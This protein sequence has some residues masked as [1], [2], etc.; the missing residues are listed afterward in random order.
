MG[1]KLKQVQLEEEFEDEFEDIP[2]D[3]FEDVEEE[4]E[5]ADDGMKEERPKMSAEEKK[6]ARAV[7]K[8]TAI[9]RK[10]ARP[11]GTLI[12]QA[13][14]LWM[15][16]AKKATPSDTRAKLMDEMMSLITGQIE[17]LVFKHDASRIIQ[18]LLK[19][20][21]SAQ[22]N[23]IASE[24][25]K[26]TVEIAK[27][28]YGKFIVSK[29]LNFC[30]DYRKGVIESFYGNVRKII[31]HRHAGLVLE[32][33]YSQFANSMQRTHLLAEFY[34]SEFVLFKVPLSNL[35]VLTYLQNDKIKSLKEILATNPEKKV[36]VLKNIRENLVSVLQKGGISI[37]PHSILHRVL[38]DY[39]TYSETSALPEMIDLVKEH[40][41]S[42]LHTREGAR[43]AQLVITHSSPKDRKIIIKS[44]KSYVHKIAIEQYGHTVLMSIFECV[45]DTVLV[46]KSIL[47]ELVTSIKPGDMAALD[48]MSTFG[49]L[50]RHP[51]ASR[52][53][54]FLLKGRERKYQPAYVINEL[55]E[56]DAIRKST[57]KKEDHLRFGELLSFISP[58]L[59]SAV[60]NHAKEMIS[61]KFG[62][63]VVLETILCA[64]DD[65]QELL[66]VLADFAKGT[67]DSLPFGETKK[68]PF[69]A[70]KKMTQE[71]RDEKMEGAIHPLL[72]RTANSVLKTL[73]KSVPEFAPLFWAQIKDQV[74]VW[75]QH[76][77]ENPTLSGT[78]L[79]FL[80]M[81]E[82]NQEIQK[83]LASIIDKKLRTTL[84]KTF[85]KAAGS[86]E[87][88]ED[89][90][91]RKMSDKKPL[92]VQLMEC[93]E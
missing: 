66:Q 32:E 2:S 29:I 19:Y 64:N 21:S 16:I 87:A 76:C 36:S 24:L 15:P 83:E 38:L 93:L 60:K 40:L 55:Q 62:S 8:T 22:R 75:I 91:K 59:L 50:S 77:A 10:L 47:A 49:D 46:T 56:I 35:L 70:V 6:Q 92:F 45:D 84:K 18:S 68:E 30:P 44:M 71:I 51:Y 25:K 65:K 27:S 23:T 41:V 34:G 14:K 11:H 20:G 28:Q 4:F 52:I 85:E 80:A 26:H 81:A 1:G 17:D 89:G 31:K 63:Q 42:I 73:I 74:K 82:T 37:G 33:A 72:D 5:E 78:T 58:Y 90:K 54:L 61:D 7:Q 12:A 67:P 39:L 88:S 86:Q 3:E 69:N 43:V 9:E 57:S 53:A 13:K 48:G 79:C